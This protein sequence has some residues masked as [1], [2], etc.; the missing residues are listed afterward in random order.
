MNFCLREHMYLFYHLLSLCPMSP[1]PS[2]I[3]TP[4]PMLFPHPRKFLMSLY[5]NFFEYEIMQNLLFKK[6]C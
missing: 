6:L 4:L 3:H 2:F 5:E 1:V